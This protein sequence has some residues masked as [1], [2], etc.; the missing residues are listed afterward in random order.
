MKK[1]NVTKEQ[2]I[3]CGACVAIDPNH[4]NFDDEGRSNVINN[5]NIESNEL[6]NAIESCPTSAISIINE[7]DKHCS[8]DNE[9]NECICNN[10]C[11]CERECICEQKQE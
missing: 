2:C 7:E 4:F 8:N 10:N 1:I 11:T 9:E 6:Q 5:E 3:G